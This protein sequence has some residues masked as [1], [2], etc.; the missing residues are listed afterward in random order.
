MKHPPCG[1]LFQSRA[2]L[3][4]RAGLSVP[5]GVRAG[6]HNKPAYFLHF[7]FINGMCIFNHVIR[8][9]ICWLAHWIT[10]AGAGPGAVQPSVLG[11]WQGTQVP[12]H[13]LLPPGVHRK[14]C[15]SICLSDPGWAGAFC[16]LLGPPCRTDSLSA[17]AH[18]QCLRA[19]HKSGFMLKTS[20]G[21]AWWPSG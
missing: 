18:E 3:A 12:G 1:D 15:V 17:R 21:P 14:A 6:A 7:F 20:A 5:A 9:L 16:S 10:A 8:A 19:W 11:M 4:R 13:P 2:S